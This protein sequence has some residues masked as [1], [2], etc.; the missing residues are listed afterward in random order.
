MV[1]QDGLLRVFWPLEKRRED[2]VGVLIGWFNSA[3]DIIV[4]SILY[5]CDIRPVE[6]ALRVGTLYRN[7]PH[8]IQ[9]LLDRCGPA[10]LQVI[11]AINRRDKDS[12]IPDDYVLARRDRN[13]VQPTILA[14]TARDVQVVLYLRPRPEQ[15]QFMSPDPMSLAIR[16]NRE[17]IGLEVPPFVEIAEAEKEELARKEHLVKKLRLHTVK[18]YPQTQ[19]ELAL[20]TV[21]TQV[22]CSEDIDAVLQ[23]NIAL[24]RQRSRRALSVSERVVE[25]ANN[26]WTYI[27]LALWSAFFEYLWPTVKSIFIY[28]LMTHRIIGEGILCFVET[29]LLTKRIALRDLS[30]SAQQVDL[31][32]QQFCYWPVQYMTLKKRKD[33]WESCSNNHAEYIRFYNSLWLV[34]NDIIIGC[35]F[36][37]YLIDNAD[38]VASL[39]DRLLAQW[40]LEGLRRMLDWLMVYPAGLKLN[41]ELAAFLGGLFIWVID[42]WGAWLSTIQ[43]HLPTLIRLFGFAS[44]AG[45]SM[46]LSL[47]S[48]L[49]S[50]CTLHIYCFYMASA[51]IY[52]WQLSIIL[53]LFHLF[54][55][56][57]RNVLRNRIDSCDYELDQL[58]L[59]TILFTLLFFLLPTVAVFYLTFAL[60]RIGIIC[61]KGICD[62][63]L[64]CLNHF[65][66]F[67][68]MLRAKDPGRLPG[69]IR[70]ELQGPNKSAPR[71]SATTANGTAHPTTSYIT[72]RSTPLTLRA[73]FHEYFQLGGQIQKHYLSSSVFKCLA[74]GV[75][76]PPLHRRNLYSL[77]YSSLPAQ[78]VGIW[79]LWKRFK[80]PVSVGLNGSAQNGSL[81]V[82]IKRVRT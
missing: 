12:I 37:S 72:L 39:F 66:L 11:G 76:V 73:M 18:K 52:N 60:A 55:G 7:V 65:P 45:A 51:R 42:Y 64:A 80:M 27:S 48:D 22:N 28:G 75:L 81:R 9:H 59:G 32:L 33:D 67:A 24:V 8:P 4:A 68:L 71:T 38:F 58:L 10:P 82:G 43:P 35:A 25:S 63:L 30:A 78:R 47:A 57:K 74:T 2:E 46:P 16:D 14:P 41:N 40:S 61:L 53:S 15:M 17:R 29:P 79:E 77:Q 54:R 1:S 56:K 19:K 5:G 21:I 20:P 50:V 62:S 69:G 70:F 36:C 34:A 13:R 26:L 49:L 23:K 6:N 3:S 44:L 31:R